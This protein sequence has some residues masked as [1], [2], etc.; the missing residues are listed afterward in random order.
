MPTVTIEEVLELIRSNE[1]ADEKRRIEREAEAEKRRKED[2]KRWKEDEKRW[3]AAERRA[4]RLDKQLGELGNWFGKWSEDYF[5]R[6][7][8]KKFLKL[9]YEFSSYGPRDFIDEN[10][11][12]VFAQVDNW[13]EN[14]DYTMA[15]EIK[16]A[17]TTEYVNDHIERLGKIRAYMDR[18]NDKRKLIGAL[19]S[20]TFKGNAENYAIKKGLY[21]I[22]QSGEDIVILPKEP[23]WKPKE[24]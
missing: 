24:Y 13:F 6:M 19:A 11:R 3:V 17:L 8:D 7:S 5:R 18:R 1:I 4:A 14:G 22:T 2:E 12:R 20:L 10:T 21:I 23:G 16:N 9:G 15:V